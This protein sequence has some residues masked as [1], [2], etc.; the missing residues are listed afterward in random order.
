MELPADT[1]GSNLEPPGE[2][3]HGVAVAEIIADVAPGARLHLHRFTTDVEFVALLERLSQDG[4]DV[5]NASIGFD[6]IWHPDGTSPM[7]EAV[8]QLARAGVAYVAAAGNEVGR[9][10]SGPLGDGDG[11]GDLDIDGETGLLV[12]APGGDLRVSLRWSEEMDAATWDLDLY[13]W[14]DVEA[15]AGGAA[16]CAASTEP[17][18][19]PGDAP[20]E[21]IVGWCG[22]GGS[23]WVV[24]VL[25]SPGDGDLADLEAHVYAP[26]GYASGEDT[27]SRTL[28]LPA[29]A[30]GAITVGACEVREGDYA[31]GGAADRY[32]SRG[33]TDDGRLKP[34]LCAA[35]AVTTASFGER[36]F[37]GTSAAAPHVAGAVA[38]IL[39][40][41]G[42]HGAPDAARVRLTRRATDLGDPGADPRYGAG[43]LRLGEAAA[44]CRCGTTPGASWA[45]PFWLVLGIT[46]RRRRPVA[47]GPPRRYPPPPAP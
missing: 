43:G 29:D 19:R 4:T 14:P 25:A 26:F 30:V 7:S 5:V 16:P 21:S 2:T 35:A 37:V 23:A 10:R 31:E 42:L 20:L 39:D 40:G 27:V 1:R 36:G 12:E 41:E 22:S 18:G 11:D 28:T 45:L 46:S 38:L 15:W 32:S 34:D 6:N 17:Q 24:P 47:D 44:R 3:A 8:D 33:P 9:Y 13:A